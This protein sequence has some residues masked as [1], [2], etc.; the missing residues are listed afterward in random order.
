M[1][2]KQNENTPHNIESGPV[3]ATVWEKQAD[4]GEVSYTIDIYRKQGNEWV[5]ASR[6]DGHD[7]HH[8]RSVL[9]DV[10]TYLIEATFEVY[11]LDGT[12]I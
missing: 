5:E 2:Q 6:F 10:D 3:R 8:L 11:T 7:I 1:E 9:T 4:D 12:P